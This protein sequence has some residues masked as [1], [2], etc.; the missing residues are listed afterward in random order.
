[1]VI[2]TENNAFQNIGKCLHKECTSETQIDDFLQF[3]IEFIFY[4]RT[5]I[6]GTV[7]PS[8]I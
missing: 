1:M 4:D 5:H 3:C 8:I 7:P 6:V 2:L